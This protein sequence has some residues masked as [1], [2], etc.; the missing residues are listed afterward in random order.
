MDYWIYRNG[1][2]K[3]LNKYSLDEFKKFIE[4]YDG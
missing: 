4:Q 2:I 1:L 3:T